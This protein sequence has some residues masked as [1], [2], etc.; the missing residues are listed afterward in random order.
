VLDDPDRTATPGNP[1]ALAY[2]P[3]RITVFRQGAA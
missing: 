2:D 1:V 3:A